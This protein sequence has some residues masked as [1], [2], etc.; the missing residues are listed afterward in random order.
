MPCEAQNS[1]LNQRSVMLASLVLGLIRF[2]QHPGLGSSGC[3]S[4]DIRAVPTA[5]RGRALRA[6]HFRPCRIAPDQWFLFW[7]L[8][9]H[10]LLLCTFENRPNWGQSI[11]AKRRILNTI[12]NQLQ[13][14]TINRCLSNPHAHLQISSLKL[15]GKTRAEPKQLQTIEGKV[16]LKTSSIWLVYNLSYTNCG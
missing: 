5:W 13:P 11:W 7:V 6:K 15:L 12:K 16:F 4:E 3:L 1:E 2:S 10:C 14:A 8:W 9:I